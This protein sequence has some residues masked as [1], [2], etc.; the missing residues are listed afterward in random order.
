LARPKG[1]LLGILVGE[2]LVFKKLL[3]RV[4][5]IKNSWLMCRNL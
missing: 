3:K 5:K 4:K 1:V 2:G